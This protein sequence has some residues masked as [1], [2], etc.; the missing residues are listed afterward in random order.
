MVRFYVWISLTIVFLFKAADS[1]LT[2]RVR[3]TEKEVNFR[4]WG[5]PGNT[6]RTELLQGPQGNSLYV[7]GHGKL[8][9][10]K[11]D[12][13]ILPEEVDFPKRGDKKSSVNPTASNNCDYDITTLHIANDS[14][15]L[16]CGTNGYHP[17]CHFVNRKPFGSFGESIAAEGIAPFSV[18]ERAPSVYVGN[19][20]YAAAN[21][22]A[23]GN[24]LAIRRLG[25]RSI[26]P[27]TNKKE[28]RYVS[29][30]LSGPRE[31]PVQDRVYTFLVERNSDT[32]PEADIWT[33]W[34]TQVCA[35]D[36]GGTKS[37]LQ[38][39]WTS[40]LS[41]R[42]SCGIPE[43]RMYFNRLV[44]VAV[45][46]AERWNDSMVYA[47][48]NNSWGMSAVCV[49]TM[50]DIDRIFTTSKFRGYND[51][52]PSARPGVC[53]KESTK[54]PSEVLRLIKDHPEM[55]S[56]VEPVRG[57]GPLMVSHRYYRHIRVDGVTG[58]DGRRHR[59]LFLSLES[60]GVHKVLD[61]DGEAFI[62]A[63][64]QP[65]PNKTRIL[66]MLLQ[67]SQR[68]LYVASSS[69]VV[70]VDLKSCQGYG[71]QCVA[72][73]QARDPYCSWDRTQCTS[74][75]RNGI[76]DVEQGNHAVCTNTDGVASPSRSKAQKIFR[77]SKHYLECPMFS[78]H[79]QYVWKHNGA[80]KECVRTEGS[81][82]LLID[83]MT[84]EHDGSYECVSSEGGYSSTVVEYDLETES[85]AGG[86]VASP[87]ASACLLL[88]L[89]L[90]G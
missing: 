40:R 44:D 8:L 23:N 56:P 90:L 85:G 26:W 36:V 72:C 17:Q 46:K 86:L 10:I 76:Q 20:L 67:S 6:V 2:P 37:I 71:D 33:S 89:A 19:E 69:E 42:L 80:D 57:G 38:K 32:R 18:T 59:V 54:L 15:L 65:F 51:N 24:S 50:G 9:Y 48:F 31:D 29:M 52:L 35:A 53:V 55:E 11:L 22:H 7:G 70:E 12:T 84:P 73:V 49:Y 39:S 75:S 81:C 14:H 77:W 87:L 27:D 68:K 83:S 1:N 88:L 63:E 21:S 28:Q 30:V 61:H 25:L 82:L 79:A 41:A 47:L 64:L 43:K 4:K 45:L 34:V 60:G 66:N 78:S 13:S 74:A 3:L 16:V 62:I 58:S 5:L